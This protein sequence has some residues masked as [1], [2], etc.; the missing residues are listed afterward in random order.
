MKGAAAV[1]AA[2]GSNR[3]AGARR[4]WAHQQQR[5]ASPLADAVQHGC[6]W[7]QQLHFT[8]GAPTCRGV[9]HHLSMGT[10]GGLAPFQQHMG[11]MEGSPETARPAEPYRSGSLSPA[12]Q[13]ALDPPC[14]PFAAPR[15]QGRHERWP[16]PT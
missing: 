10:I 1:E 11:P 4:S 15:Q 5:H 14:P 8:R 12:W 13:T 2:R 9:R 3:A 7:L 6:I 16:H